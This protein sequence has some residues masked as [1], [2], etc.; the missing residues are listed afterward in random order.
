MLFLSFK[1]IVGACSGIV[2]GLDVFKAGLSHGESYGVDLRV[3]RLSVVFNCKIIW[4]D[5]A[6]GWKGKR[7]CGLLCQTVDELHGRVLCKVEGPVS[8]DHVNRCKV[9]LSHF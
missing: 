7:H 2:E 5:S 8:R 6:D 1:R 4:L 9:C 3:A